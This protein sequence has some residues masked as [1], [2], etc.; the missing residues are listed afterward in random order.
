MNRRFNERKRKCE[1]FWKEQNLKLGE[2][3]R[4][5]PEKYKGGLI[6]I[7]AYGYTDDYVVGHRPLDARSTRPNQL[8]SYKIFNKEDDN[9]KEWYYNMFDK[10][11]K[12][13]FNHEF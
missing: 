9:Y 12:L 11:N 1:K 10:Y 6:Q 4:K 8:R 7:I 2:D 5:H 13:I 3:R